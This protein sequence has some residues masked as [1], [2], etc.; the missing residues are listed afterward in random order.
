MTE[1]HD[2]RTPVEH[3]PTGMRALLASLP[4]PGPMP[5]DLVARITAALAAEAD[6]AAATGSVATSPAPAVDAPVGPTTD[7]AP[8]SGGTVVPLPR[9][10]VRL[11]HL[12][13]AAAVVGALGLGGVVL[14]T[15]P[16]GLTASIGA[17]GGADSAQDA[18][19]AAEGSDDSGAGAPAAALVP[20]P[21][22][23]EVVIVM[24]GRSYTAS[25]LAPRARDLA[26][27][28]DGDRLRSLA[29][30][31]PGIGPIGTP[32]G[33]RACT[34]ALG[35]PASAGVLVD[36]AEVDGRPAAVLVVD[37]GAGPTAYA[38]ARSCTTGTTGL[39]SGPVPLG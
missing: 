14:S 20:P 17:V 7:A 31:A 1:S 38:V 35:V 32:L 8:S 2:D 39:I 26:A 4:E 34:D 11:R 36:V 19:S 5:D 9:R 15:T 24:S 23:G 16:N 22:S 3:D 29:A 28:P 25:D 6:A 37:T 21:G 30:E 12:G 10:R 27:Q 13:V 18:E 33:A